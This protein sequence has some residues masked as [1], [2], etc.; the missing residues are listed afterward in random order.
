MIT[1]KDEHPP[2]AV[3][4][5][6]ARWL[7]FLVVA[8]GLQVFE[9]ALPGLG[10]WFKPGLANIV[11]LLVLVLMGVQAAWWLAVARVVVGAF[12]M[13]TLFSP[14]F[15]MSLS[16]AVAA[17]VVMLLAWRYIPAITLL[18][19]SLLGALAH[20]LAQFVVVEQLFIQQPSLFYLLSPLLLLSCATG[21]LNGA[22]AAYIIQ[23][24]KDG[25]HHA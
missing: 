7:G 13:G 23:R 24:M 22:L 21:W 12:M 6:H 18:G 14:T 3:L 10:P 2:I 4:L 1:M 8:S 16:G 15:V 11:T 17:M 25:V 20:M 9:A 5:F 19:V